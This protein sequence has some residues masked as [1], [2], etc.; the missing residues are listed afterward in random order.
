MVSDNN[1]M[2]EA[3]DL[4]WKA[5][6]EAPTSR[7]LGR[8]KVDAAVSA[9]LEW[10]PHQAQG[11]AVA[12]LCREVYA[13]HPEMNTDWHDHRPLEP[14]SKKHAA[15]SESGNW[16]LLPVFDRP[17]APSAVPDSVKNALSVL[18]KSYY[19]Q[20]R[21]DF[22]A[23]DRSPGYVCGDINAVLITEI[24]EWA[25]SL[26]TSAKSSAVPDRARECLF[27]AARPTDLDNQ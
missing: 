1:D 6:C 7:D 13:D 27:A 3:K 2:R 26:A 15:R 10:Q 16:E 22:E 20:W 5:F 4:A 17:P 8:S 25:R 11:E 19:R 12:V 18:D 14:G 9:A 24:V 21:R 23:G